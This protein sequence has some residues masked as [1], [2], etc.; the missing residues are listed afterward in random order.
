MNHS[1]IVNHRRDSIF[2]QK[3]LQL[4]SPVGL[5]GILMKCVCTVIYALRQPDF[6]NVFKCSSYQ[7]LPVAAL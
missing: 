3:L 1:R 5:N 7:L 6:F 4:I 2:F